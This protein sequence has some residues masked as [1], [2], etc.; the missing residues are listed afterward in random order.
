MIDTQTKQQIVKASK[1]IPN[2]IVTLTF[3][4]MEVGA[5][6]RG[7]VRTAFVD[8]EIRGATVSYKEHKKFLSSTFY[9]VKIVADAVLMRDIVDYFERI[10][11]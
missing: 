11:D 8:M 6:I 7:G 10:N 9:N 1:E 5:A 2:T 4:H 3:T